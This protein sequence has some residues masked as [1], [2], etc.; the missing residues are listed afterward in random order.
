[1]RPPRQT[2]WN[3]FRPHRCVAARSL[4]FALLVLLALCFSAYAEGRRALVVFGSAVKADGTPSRQ[5]VRRLQ[6]TLELARRDPA[7]RIVVTGG[8]VTAP[9]PEGKVMARWLQKR[10]VNPR[11]IAVEPHA[12]HTGENAELAVPLLKKMGATDVTVVTSRYHT[13]R[14]GYHMRAALRDAGLS[15]RVSVRAAPDG[16]RGLG[17]LKAWWRES[18]KIARDAGFRLRRRQKR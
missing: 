7:A 17:R 16:L 14:A 3:L 6:T 4:V 1:M 12:R 15:P 2:R 18:F 10:G 11:R 9:V 5:L 8:S 13:R